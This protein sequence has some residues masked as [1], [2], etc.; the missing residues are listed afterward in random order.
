MRV[1]KVYCT[2]FGNRRGKISASPSNDV[3]ALKVIRNN[4]END[5]VFDCGVKNM[6]IIIINNKNPNA[7]IECEN[8][9]KSINNIITQYGKIVVYERENRGGS[10]GAF[11]YAFNLFENEYD[12]WLFLEDD[13][14]M[15]YPKYYEM[16]INEFK[17]DNNLGFL[18]LTKIN[19][20]GTPDRYVSGGFGAS[21]KEILIKIKQK[22][23]KLPYDDVA[24]GYGNFGRSE[25]MFTNCYIQVGYDV[26]IPNDPH[27]VTLADNWEMHDPHV[28]WQKMK[29]F[30][31]KNKSF[32]CHMGI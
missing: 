1:C 26:R 30:D 29:N 24:H 21:K 12:Y 4:I 17:N 15:I 3:E 27:V 16:I 2:Y 28:L 11:N 25:F 5:M 13:I 9:L 19:H 8:Y 20:D 10:M 6:D 7:N 32:L 14:K 23:G 22:Y 31:L 18:A